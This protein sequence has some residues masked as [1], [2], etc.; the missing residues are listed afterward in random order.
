LA[1]DW[2]RRLRRAAAYDSYYLALADLLKC[3]LWTADQ[4]LVDAAAVPWV[5]LVGDSA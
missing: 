2:T 1:F 4:H 5:R 3:D